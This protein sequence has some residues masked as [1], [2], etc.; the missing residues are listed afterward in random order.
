MSIASWIAIFFAGI[1]LPVFLAGGRSRRQKGN[2][3]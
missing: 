3:T 1:F 2:R